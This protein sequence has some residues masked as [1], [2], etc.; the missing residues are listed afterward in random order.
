[1][2]IDLIADLP[3]I[4]KEDFEKDYYSLHDEIN[5]QIYRI[6]GSRF[7]ISI[8]DSRVGKPSTVAIKNMKML[9]SSDKYALQVLDK[10]KKEIF[11]IGL[12][13]PF[14][15]HAQHIDFE[16]R[17][18]FGGYVDAELEIALPFEVDVAYFI[19]FSQEDKFLKKIDSNTKYRKNFDGGI[20]NRNSATTRSILSLAQRGQGPGP[21]EERCKKAP[22]GIY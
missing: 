17:D 12:G 19:L 6:E 16:D 1:M 7:G 11:M 4:L 5:A 8:K 9:S 22:K 13:D 2:C 15:I 10:S 20:L 14:Y 21:A 18:F 3:P